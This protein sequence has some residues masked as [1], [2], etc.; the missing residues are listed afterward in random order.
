M[1]QKNR[2]QKQLLPKKQQ[3]FI[4]KAKLWLV[5]LCV[6]VSNAMDGERSY[7]LTAG[8][9][10][11]QGSK[12]YMEDVVTMLPQEKC[13]P[14][15]G[16]YDGHCG[17]AV[18]EYAGKHLHTI[19]ND[20]VVNNPHD[21]IEKHFS[22]SF[23]LID[24]R[25][26]ELNIIEPGSSALVA[27]VQ[28]D[29]LHCA[30]AG[31]TRAILIH[32][33]KVIFATEDHKPDSEKE[34]IIKAGGWVNGGRVYPDG[35]GMSRAFGDLKYE[36]KKRKVVI[37]DPETKTVSIKPGSTLVM[38]TDGYWDD[39][40][41]EA[42]REKVTSYLKKSSAELKE[43]SAEYIEFPEEITILAGDER[44][45]IIAQLLCNDAVKAYPCSDGINKNRCDNISVLLVTF[46]DKLNPKAVSA[47]PE[48]VP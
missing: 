42:A 32:D 6:N 12:P 20:L 17:A 4:V 19:F 47:G 3:G 46:N 22:N 8:F 23:T 7:E 13:G 31:D 25:L 30:W 27:F 2:K 45:K 38:A 34:R 29:K 26:A 1:K 39:I 5:F 16:M 41:Q 43:L 40:S 37:V 28:K 44:L 18:A 9:Y 21:T 10:A 33:G 15:F 48:S 36:A 35:F 11:R 24:K 14:F